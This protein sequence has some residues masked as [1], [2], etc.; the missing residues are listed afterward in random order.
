MKLK[1]L[2]EDIEGLP[3]SKDPYSSE[4]EYD[5]LDDDLEVGRQYADTDPEPYEGEEDAPD[6]DYDIDNPPIY[7]DETLG[8]DELTGEEPGE[9]EPTSPPWEPFE[10]P[11]KK[12]IGL[13]RADGFMLRARRIES[14]PGKW[15]AQLWNEEW[16]E[17]KVIEEKV[18]DKGFLWIP[19]DVDPV[20]FVSKIADTMLDRDTYR[21]QQNPNEGQPEVAMGGPEPGLE[22]E[23]LGEEPGL[24]EEP[25]G[26]GEPGLEEEPEGLGEPGLEE[27]PGEDIGLS[28]ENFEFE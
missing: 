4:E 16:N 28:D 26:L 13:K 7:K 20:E 2:T 10:L 22:E 25:E 6:Y 18:I 5:E 23:P 11:N 21:Y 15:V 19:T 8:M 24:E 9:P 3:K 14:V 12:D 1:L 27:E 17:E